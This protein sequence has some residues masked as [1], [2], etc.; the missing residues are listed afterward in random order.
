MNYR[1]YELHVAIA[2]LVESETTNPRM[3]KDDDCVSATSDRIAG[4]SGGAWLPAGLAC[5]LPSR[6]KVDSTYPST[7]KDVGQ[8]T[9]G[10]AH[11]SQARRT[12]R[13]DYWSSTKTDVRCRGRSIRAEVDRAARQVMNAQDRQISLPRLWRSASRRCSAGSVQRK[14]SRG[15]RGQKEKGGEATPRSATQCCRALDQAKNTQPDPSKGTIGPDNLYHNSWAIINTGKVLLSV[16]SPTH[17]ARHVI[18]C[19]RLLNSPTLIGMLQYPKTGGD[20]PADPRGCID[21]QRIA[22]L[23]R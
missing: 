19:A 17:D 5:R 16:L 1:Y 9:R 12:R 21:R 7:A 20:Y 15:R 18:L 6:F 22:S 11:S 3:S 8:P 4:E 14:A 10:A 2:A 23:P 13:Q